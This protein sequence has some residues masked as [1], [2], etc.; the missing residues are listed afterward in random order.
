MTEM[1]LIGVAFVCLGA[2]AGFVHL[3]LLAWNIR[4]LAGQS[5][6]PVAVCMSLSRVIL[7]PAT[8]VFAVP[9]GAPALAAML[10]GFLV[11]RSIVLRRAEIFVP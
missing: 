9:H 7:T 1:A 10:A 11:S 3:K 4:G 8:F 5:C 2:A 6:G